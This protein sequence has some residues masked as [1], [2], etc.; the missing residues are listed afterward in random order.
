MRCAVALALLIVLSVDLAGLALPAQQAPEKPADVSEEERRPYYPP[1][2]SKSVEIGNFYLR[3]KMLKG[4]LSRFQEAINTD[5]HYAPA[6][7]GLGKVYEKM[8]LRRK[9]LAAY[10]RYLDEL[11]STKDALE[12]KDIQKAIVRLNKELKARPPSRPKTSPARAAP[13]H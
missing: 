5:P 10:Q 7:L 11:P 8:G 13:S 2:A 1:G 4:A 3:R 9:A 6:Y 12:A